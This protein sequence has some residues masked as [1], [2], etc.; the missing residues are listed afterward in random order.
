MTHSQDLVA[1]VEKINSY[2]LTRS[3]KLDTFHQDE[4]SL[5]LGMSLPILLLLLICKNLPQENLH[6]QT[7]DYS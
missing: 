7:E 1:A 5:E 4:I 6:L 3:S 2:L